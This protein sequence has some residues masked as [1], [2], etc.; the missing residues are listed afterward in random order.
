[1]KGVRR[2]QP[3]ACSTPPTRPLSKLR[4]VFT[5]MEELDCRELFAAAVPAIQPARRAPWSGGL[6]LQAHDQVSTYLRAARTITAAGQDAGCS[7][8]PAGPDPRSGAHPRCPANDTQQTGWRPREMTKLP[9]IKRVP[10]RTLRRDDHA[11]GHS[12]HLSGMVRAR[13]D[14]QA[15]PAA[16]SVAA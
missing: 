6:R 11:P 1:M 13:P 12:D 8:I 4:G 9:D 5:S 2:G 7:P 10:S 16:L 15:A 3:G 14:T